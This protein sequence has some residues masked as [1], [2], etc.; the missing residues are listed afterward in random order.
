MELVLLGMFLGEGLS[1]AERL[2]TL[3]HDLKPYPDFCPLNTDRIQV[4]IGTYI[5]PSVIVH[6]ARGLQAAEDVI[7][8]RAMVEEWN[9]PRIGNAVMFGL[10]D[11]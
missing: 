5:R 9:F 3:A 7:K 6:V 4:G 2:L 10:V 8:L 11:P 1:I